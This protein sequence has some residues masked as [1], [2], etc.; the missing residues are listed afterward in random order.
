MG[1]ALCKFIQTIVMGATS[2]FVYVLAAV[3]LLPLIPAF[4]LYKFLPSRTNVSGPFK[5]LNLKLTGAFGG[6][7]LLV[8]TAIGVFF[9]LLKNEQSKIIEQQ[10]EKIKQLENTISDRQQ[11]TM[12]GNV[13]STSP[14]QTKAFFDE[15][16]TSFYETGE[17][18]MNFYA[19][20]QQGKPVLPKALCIYNKDDGYKVLNLSRDF[21]SDD[22]KNFGIVFDDSA[23]M[24][25]I[26]S[27]IDIQSKAK[28]KIDAEN[29]LLNKI[30]TKRI[31]VST[32]K[33]EEAI[34]LIKPQMRPDLKTGI[35]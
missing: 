25:K 1:K 10:D 33:P 13:I 2:T 26:D 35:K 34:R 24:I 14:K 21:K 22:I 30:R 19:D 31:N 29:D 16:G 7:F 5:G 11:W 18:A 8:I 23:H 6:Y 17:F 15:S 32:Y 3:L 27:A 9:P 4:L 12:K 20:L 28:A